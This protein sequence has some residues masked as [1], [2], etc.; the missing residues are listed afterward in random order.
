MTERRRSYS[1]TLCIIALKTPIIQNAVNAQMRRKQLK[2]LKKSLT[3]R[4]LQSLNSTNLKQKRKLIH[5]MKK[6][7]KLFYN[8]CPPY[9]LKN[10][11]FPNLKLPVRC[12]RIQFQKFDISK[13]EEIIK[14]EKRPFC[15]FLDIPSFILHKI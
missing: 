9:I 15:N 11:N 13:N 3:L 14:E 2:S 7:K 1:G 4:R 5:R 6:Y 10:I 8:N 12:W